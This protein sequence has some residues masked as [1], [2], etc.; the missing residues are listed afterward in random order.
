MT[1]LLVLL[2]SP[3]KAES[4]EQLQL[5][6]RYARAAMKDSLLRGEAPFAS[7]LLYTQEGVLDD[8]DL[9]ERMTGIFA[10]L[11]WGSKADK[12]VVYVD[13]GISRGMELG[14]AKARSEGR[15]AEFRHLEGWGTN[16]T[17][18]TTEPQAQ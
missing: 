6:L 18:K 10:G 11:D 13:L 12:T 4:P 5:H 2:E 17:P 3:Y 9:Q 16:A 1:R 15:T 8:N 7:H 14:I